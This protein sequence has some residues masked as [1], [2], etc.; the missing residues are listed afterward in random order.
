MEVMPGPTVVIGRGRSL[1]HRHFSPSV[2]A[3]FPGFHL[4]QGHLALDLMPVVTVHHLDRVV[5]LFLA[6]SPSIEIPLDLER[7]R[8]PLAAESF[9][10]DHRAP[11]LMDITKHKKTL[12]DRPAWSAKDKR[13]FSRTRTSFL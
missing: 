13:P 11:K 8:L 2:L 12:P 7:T 3:K 4:E 10:E 9:D 6:R 5:V 1:G